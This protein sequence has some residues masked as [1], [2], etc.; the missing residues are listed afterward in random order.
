MAPALSQ[1]VSVLDVYSFLP[2]FLPSFVPH[3][4]VI[5]QPLFPCTSKHHCLWLLPLAS[6]S[7]YWTCIPSFLPSFIPHLQVI[8]HLPSFLPSFVPHLQVITQPL[9]P[10]TSKHHCLWL[11]PLASTSLYWTCIPSFLPSFVPHLQVITQPLFPCT[12]KHHCLW[13][14]PLAS[15]SLYWTCIPWWPRPL[16]VILRNEWR[17]SSPRNT[18]TMWPVDCGLIYSFLYV[19]AVRSD[20]PI[21][22][23]RSKILC[24]FCIS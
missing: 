3:L 13:L 7:L 18:H 17:K 20:H 1:Y 24:K 23:A 10:C 21:P 16:Y 4:Q 2:S 12:S 9:F 8:T 11:L 6:T 5:T 22:N 15:T 14:L 19:I